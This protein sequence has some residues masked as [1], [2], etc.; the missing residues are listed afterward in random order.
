[1][2]LGDSSCPGSSNWPVQVVGFLCFFFGYAGSS[3]RHAR[4]SFV[5]C[6]LSCRMWDLAP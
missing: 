4:S 5:A 3:F 2:E 6:E 1:M